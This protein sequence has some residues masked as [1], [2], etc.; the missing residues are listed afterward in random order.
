MTTVL[1]LVTHNVI[2]SKTGTKQHAIKLEAHSLLS[3]S[4]T[5]LV[6]LL[7][8]LPNEMQSHWRIS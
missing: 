4:R 6:E 5:A 8:L 2:Q 3:S 1:F 7:H